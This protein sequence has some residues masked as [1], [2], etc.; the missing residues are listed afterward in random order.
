MGKCY[1]LVLLVLLSCGGNDEPDFIEDKEEELM[2]HEFE[3]VATLSHDGENRD[4]LIH[5]PPNFYS[6]EK[7]RPM[8][9]A[10][11]GGG[12]S[13]DGFRTNTAFDEKADEEDFIA[14]FPGGLINNGV[15]TWNAGRCCG[16]NAEAA[17]DTDDVGFI[18]KMIDQMIAGYHVDPQRVYSTGSSNGAGITYRLM[19]ELSDKI[20]AFAAN[21][22]S[23]TYD[24]ECPGVQA[25]P[26]L[27]THSKIDMNHPF[28]GGIAS[29]GMELPHSDEYLHGLFARVA[30]SPESSL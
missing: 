27:H 11:H 24:G 16:A 5:L 23:D 30:T 7:V 21:A 18:S 8:V 2:L 10:F 25:R 9:M 14:V 3:F 13:P 26:L 15:R 4:F 17:L 29:N 6:E 19:C 28:E 1:Y 22:G 20:A 12:G